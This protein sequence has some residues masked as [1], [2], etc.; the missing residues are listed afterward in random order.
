MKKRMLLLSLISTLCIGSYECHAG[1]PRSVPVP[2]SS[3]TPFSS[4]TEVLFNTTHQNPLPTENAAAS[5]F[6]W[7]R[8]VLDDLR[9]LL[10]FQALPSEPTF[11]ATAIPPLG[12]LNGGRN[13]CYFNA[14]MQALGALNID[15]NSFRISDDECTKLF[16]SLERT[17]GAEKAH[18]IVDRK[19]LTAETVSNLL[20]QLYGEDNIQAFPTTPISG[21]GL[22]NTAYIDGAS[23][24]ENLGVAIDGHPH[25]PHELFTATLL[26]PQHFSFFT[27]ETIFCT[28]C[29][30]ISKNNPLAITHLN[31]NLAKDKPELSSLLENYF[32]P[33]TI[34]YR[35]PF[36]ETFSKDNIKKTL[37]ISYPNILAIQLLRY[38]FDRNTMRP[39]KINCPV[40][41]PLQMDLT[42][43]A[44]QSTLPFKAQYRL[45][46]VICHNGLTSDSGHYTAY[47]ARDE[48]W[49]LCDDTSVKPVSE[50]TLKTAQVMEQTY[51]V[52]YEKVNP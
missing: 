11:E 5:T 42:S 50:D 31:V 40:H 37:V 1:K 12:L 17:E 9:S 28:S 52:F 44:D 43:F 25:D 30:Q 47:V 35:C 41:C 26:L 7:N 29:N 46:A 10:D 45:K 20:K 3:P 14:L 19:V 21:T 32:Y 23:V 22:A 8:R 4:P 49:Y 34:E 33:T 36:C 51:M 48:D 18:V 27:A 2:S 6:V 24:L 13:I 38:D 39:V 15:K 16:D